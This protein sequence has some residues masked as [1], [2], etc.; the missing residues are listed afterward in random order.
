MV[1]SHSRWDWWLDWCR[2]GEVNESL[3]ESPESPG[4][5]WLGNGSISEILLPPRLISDRNS[6]KT[7][8]R[9]S[10]LDKEDRTGPVTTTSSPPPQLDL[11]QELDLVR[12]RLRE[13]EWFLPSERRTT[14]KKRLLAFCCILFGLLVIG[15]SIA[16]LFVYLLHHPQPPHLRVTAA[17][18][19]TGH[20]VD[21]LPP[22]RRRPALSSDLYVV[23][24]IGNP[25][26]KAGVA[27]PHMQL[28][29]YL[30]G[31]LIGTQAV[32]PPVCEQ[33]PGAST[34]RAV[35][36]A[37]REAAMSPEDAEAWRNVT[38]KGRPVRMQLV[39]RFQFQAQRNLGRWLP[40]R[41]WVYPS[42]TLW[43][44]PPP[45]G[46]LHRARC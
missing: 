19:S 36:L 18:R 17:N 42:C 15:A 44:D 26:T 28:D 11:E 46:T 10:T 14:T 13:A 24:A 20:V 43:L 35:H 22:P 23:A 16:I 21:Q 9:I 6:R 31:W 29:L 27:L 8:E 33:A 32:R 25:N 41:Y 34:V 2:S 7:L 5:R 3:P 1:A 12:L 38:G 39:G 45:A 40:F 37:V 30:R 4:S